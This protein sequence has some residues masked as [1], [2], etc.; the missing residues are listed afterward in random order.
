MSLRRRYG[1]AVALAALLTG[2]AAAAEATAATAS[3]RSAGAALYFD[4][5]LPGGRPVIGAHMRLPG[6][7]GADAA[8]VRCHRRSGLG[9]AE[10]S[11]SIPPIASRYLM[12][13]REESRLGADGPI[14]PGYH[15]GRGAYDDATLA[16]AIREGIVPG[17]GR[18][19]ELMPHYDLDERTMRSLL[20]HLKTLGSVPA[21]G[22]TPDTLH[23][24]TIITPDA[25]PI[26]RQAMLDVLTGY[27]AAPI[28]MA[29]AP[30][31][32]Q[33]ERRKIGFRTGGR[34]W[35]LHVWQ[36]QGS[37]GTWER[38]LQQRLAAEPVFAVLSGL[39]GRDW[40]PVHRF[41]ERERVPCLLPNVALPVVDEDDFYPLYFSRGVLL[42]AQLAAHW[43]MTERSATTVRRVIQVYRRDDIG[44]AAAASLRALLVKQGIAVEDHALHPGADREAWRRAA[45]D[46][47]ASD[48]LVLWAR[49][50]D[51]AGLPA[52][53]PR[54][55]TV[56]VS[57]L[58]AGMSAAPLPPQWRSRVHMTYP[59]NLPARGGPRTALPRVWFERNQI[60]IVDEAVQIDTYIACAALSEIIGNLFDQY[61]R[62]LLV[63]RFEDMLGNGI[64]SGRYPRF[65]L[66]PGQRFA[67]KGGYIVHYPQEAGGQPMADG[68]W[69]AP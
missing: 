66:A 32:M 53:G 61:S 18:L 49:P 15:V 47:G 1:L 48:A 26:A 14:A 36:L 28:P 23:F 42:E 25:D 13:P 67:S 51:L 65:G 37:P 20:A 63:E 44:A 5:V 46:A 60:A 4:G 2:T 68:D 38:Q 40:S 43:L 11:Y 29:G 35:A 54:T 17:G 21:P 9:S 62:E 50:A 22:V 52:G 3:A 27:F 56:L 31:K 30:R 69:I 57:G 12:Q 58:M 10:G 19:N 41:C 55:D 34:H 8:C 64:N 24:V 39:G 7:R 45:L 6:L 16:R 59:A 33:H